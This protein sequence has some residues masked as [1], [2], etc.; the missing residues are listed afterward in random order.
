MTLFSPS[1]LK[2]EKMKDIECCMASV[3]CTC[4]C[5]DS[6]P[7]QVGPRLWGHAELSI[8]ETVEPEN[9]IGESSCRQTMNMAERHKN[10]AMH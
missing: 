2:P 4:Y 10:C 8:E 3:G 1:T 5:L 6:A 9:A 7:S